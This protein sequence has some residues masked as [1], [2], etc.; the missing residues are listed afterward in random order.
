[1]RKRQTHSNVGTQSHEPKR[2]SRATEVKKY[3]QA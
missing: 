3:T 2:G 1:M